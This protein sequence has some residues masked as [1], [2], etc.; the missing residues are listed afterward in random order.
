MNKMATH[1]HL[2]IIALNVKALIYVA[3]RRLAIN[4]RTH[5]DWKWG[6]KKR[7]FMQMETKRK[8]EH[9]EKGKTK[10]KVNRRKEITKIRA[11]INWD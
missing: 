5:R 11:E 3:Y 9:L 6:D 7:Y 8:V 4:I 10:P 1:T 2:S